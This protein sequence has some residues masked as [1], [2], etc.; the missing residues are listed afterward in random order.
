MSS[1]Y[2]LIDFIIKLFESYYDNETS[3]RKVKFNANQNKRRNRIS[4]NNKRII[5]P[6]NQVAKPLPL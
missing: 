3:N 5:L 6:K 1:A 2:L 4:K